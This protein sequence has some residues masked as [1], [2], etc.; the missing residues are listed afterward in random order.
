MSLAIAWRNPNPVHTTK[1]C[2]KFEN[3][4]PS[5]IFIVQEL[6]AREKGGQW[7]NMFVLEVLCSKNVEVSRASDHA[8][9]ESRAAGD[10]S[11][12]TSGK[13]DRPPMV[14]PTFATSACHAGSWSNTILHPSEVTVPMKAVN[15]AP[16]RHINITNWRPQDWIDHALFGIGQVS[17][18]RG[19][20]LDID[21]VDGGRKTLLK[22]TALNR[23]VAPSANV[24]LPRDKSKTRARQLK[25]KSLQTV[26]G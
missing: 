16:A 11:S 4:L 22:S 14:R 15:A 8:S 20:K 1:R 6:I 5:D 23:A 21:F 18:C 10:E 25:V 19:D 13:L 3:D 24:K 26:T 2:I 7:S 17:E 9:N 12:R